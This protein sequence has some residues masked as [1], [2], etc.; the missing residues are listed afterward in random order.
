MT[1]LISRVGKGNDQYKHNGRRK[2]D[3]MN[4]FVLFR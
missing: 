4:T 2:E 1:L 3:T